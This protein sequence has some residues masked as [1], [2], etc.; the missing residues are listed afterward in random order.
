MQITRWTRRF[1][2]S[3]LVVTL[4]TVA[5]F[6]APGNAREIER[7]R[8]LVTVGGCNDCHTEGFA[9]SAGKVPQAR[10]LTGSSLGSRGDWGTT[11]PANLRLYMQGLNADEWVRRARAL[12]TRPPMPWFVLREIKE[13]DLRAMHAFIRSLGPA[14]EPAPPYLPPGQ[15]PKGPVILFPGP[16]PGAK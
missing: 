7:G 6:A 1:A 15:E 14:G 8:Y 9:P 16:P 5:A 4:F 3:A 11:Y 12:E 2:L 10:W 13:A